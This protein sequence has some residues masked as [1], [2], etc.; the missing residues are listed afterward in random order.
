MP[1]YVVELTKEQAAQLRSEGFKAE[2]AQVSEG[3][4]LP[5]RSHAVLLQQIAT[6]LVR[7]K[8]KGTTTIN[9]EEATPEQEKAVDEFFEDFGKRTDYL[10]KSVSTTFST[11]SGSS[12]KL[13]KKL[14][15]KG[16]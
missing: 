1:Y 9:G 5:R 2:L 14:R 11:I 15:K 16:K 4:L 3:S 6:S 7:A 10:W 8:E 12:E 13:F